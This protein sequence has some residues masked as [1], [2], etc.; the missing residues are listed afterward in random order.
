M[1]IELVARGGVS[2]TAE[3][4]APLAALA[5]AIVVGGIGLA[6]LGKS[7]LQGFLIYFV[8]PLLEGW[9][10]QEVAVKAAPLI[11]IATGLCFCYR[12]NLWNI[13]AEGQFVV[14][15]VAGGWLAIFAQ[16]RF[17]DAASAWWLLPAILILGAAAGA[18]YALIPAALRVRLGVSEILSSLM[19]VYI[20]QLALDYLVRG[21]LRD[22]QGFNFPQSVTFGDAAH[23]PYLMEGERL[24]L[25][26]VFALILPIVAAFVFSRTIFGYQ[27]R[28]AGSS[29]RAA[30][31]GGFDERRLP[32]YVFAI[33]GG[34]AGLAGICEVSGQIGQVLP[35]ISPGYGFTAIIV[36]FL[37][38]LSPLP[39]VVAGLVLALTYIGGESAQIAMKLPLD[40][41]RA[42]QGILLMCVLAADTMRRYRLRVVRE[43]VA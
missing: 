22:P 42:F 14:G 15:G 34:A 12:A 24:H 3:I 4:F 6:L 26:V 35:S 23:L 28:V 21:P 31:F 10:L 36:A 13:G 11:I 7:P 20:A 2:R 43:A 38:R 9:S 25:G 16:T 1:R 33:S 5:L 41:T 32:L 29:P 39:I 40:V 30:R 17:G 19:L 27:V 37:G 18:L 8:N